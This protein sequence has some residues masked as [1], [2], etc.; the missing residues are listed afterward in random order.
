MS[1]A[2]T[3]L[4]NVLLLVDITSQPSAST[5]TVI[6]KLYGWRGTLGEG[7]GGIVLFVIIII[8]QP[9]AVLITI[10]QKTLETRN[11]YMMKRKSRKEK[12]ENTLNGSQCVYSKLGSL[13]FLL[14][15]SEGRGGVIEPG[16]PAGL[17][18]LNYVTPF[19]SF[20]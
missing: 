10:L 16:E 5:V 20:P 15:L 8:P 19:V 3:A 2:V 7:G 4:L 9:K 12:S 1:P 14:R 6:E 13:F 11:E 17:L 18:L